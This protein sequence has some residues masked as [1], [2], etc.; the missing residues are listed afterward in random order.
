MA[1]R[2]RK[3]LAGILIRLAQW[4]LRLV[5]TMKS[6]R[7]I[8]RWL[9][10]SHVHRT[11]TSTKRITRL[12]C[13]LHV[14]RRLSDRLLIEGVLVAQAADDILEVILRPLSIQ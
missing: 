6:R 4:L 1:S 7:R 9:L 11:R 8:R 13:L 10:R 14:A 2:A 3:I 12:A 5:T